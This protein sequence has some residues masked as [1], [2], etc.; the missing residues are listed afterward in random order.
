MVTRCLLSCLY[1]C[2]RLCCSSFNAHH[3][4]LPYFIFVIVVLYTFS[5]SRSTGRVSQS[6]SQSDGNDKDNDSNGPKPDRPRTSHVAQSWRLKGSYWSYQ[7]H[8]YLTWTTRCTGLSRLAHPRPLGCSIRLQSIPPCLTLP[9]T[10]GQNPRSLLLAA[11]FAQ[12]IVH[13]SRFHY[14][15]IDFSLS[16]SLPSFLSSVKF[17]CFRQLLLQFQLFGR[18]FVTFLPSR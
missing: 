5:V 10:D 6:V 2:G 18:P 4:F 17:C 3:Y 9:V 13:T 14:Q 15:S 8:P 12:Y 11:H 7:I 1:I 16:P